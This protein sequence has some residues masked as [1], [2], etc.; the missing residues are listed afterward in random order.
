[1][2]LGV[3]YFWYWC[4]VYLFNHIQVLRVHAIPTSAP[5]SL[6][7]SSA[8]RG[9]IVFM[10][11]AFLGFLLGFLGPIF[12]QFMLSWAG[13][14]GSRVHYPREYIRKFAKFGVPCCIV[15]GFVSAAAATCLILLSMYGIQYAP[16]PSGFSEGTTTFTD[17]I[18]VVFWIAIVFSAFTVLILLGLISVLIGSN[19]FDLGALKEAFLFG[20]TP[21]G[22]ECFSLINNW[23]LT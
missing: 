1:M 4:S 16:I 23:S 19:I 21:K 13:T 7:T 20:V 12:A 14:V 17:S 2:Q 22:V 18:R 11:W 5:Q 15:L 6:F 9:S 10:S 8:T 3:I